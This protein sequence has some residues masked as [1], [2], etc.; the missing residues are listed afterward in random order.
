MRPALICRISSVRVGGA[1]RGGELESIRI[2]N[3]RFSEDR[4]GALTEA[5]RLKIARDDVLVVTGGSFGRL[6]ACDQ[7]D[8]DF[9][10]VHDGT[11]SDADVLE[12][13]SIC[14]D[15]VHRIVG[16]QPAEGGAFAK[17]ERVE[18]MLANIGGENDGNNKITRR[19]LFMLE[20]VPLLNSAKKDEYLKMLVEKYVKD[21]ITDHQLAMFFLNDVIRYYRTIC[22]DFEQK[23]REGNKPW[24][25][26]NI[27]LVYSR[28]ILYFSGVIVAAEVAQMTCQMKRKVMARLLGMSPC[29]RI[30]DVCGGRADEAL[31]LFEGFLEKMADKDVRQKLNEIKGPQDGQRCEI[32]REMK[33]DSHRFSWAL[34]RLLRDKYDAGHPIH[35]ALIL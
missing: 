21:D 32:Y 27:K 28:K 30:V 10:V 18:N 23:T 7:S 19:I 35:R 17:P 11:A 3:R 9:Y 13:I 16:K 25:I 12:I 4:I 22:V 2:R 8:L 15:I 34:M 14:T 5:L 33:N 29:D 26:R 24:G 31:Q 1:Y 20:S 6:E